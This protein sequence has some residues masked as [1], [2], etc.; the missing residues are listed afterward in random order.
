MKRLVPGLV[1]TL[2]ALYLV[3]LPPLAAAPVP[4]AADQAFLASLAAQR[5]LDKEVTPKCSASVDCLDGTTISCSSSTGTSSCSSVARDCFDNERGSVTCDGVTS[6]CPLCFV[7]GGNCTALQEQ[8]T[9]H[10]ACGVMTFQCNPYVCLCKT[11]T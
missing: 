9:E 8:C 10:C 4:S 7:V 6:Q 2:A 1:L 11:C 5:P 3:T